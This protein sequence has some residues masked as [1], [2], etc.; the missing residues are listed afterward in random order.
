MSRERLRLELDRLRADG[1]LDEEQ[2]RRVNERLAGALFP[3]ADRVGTLTAI[4]ATFGA[5]LVGTGILFIVAGNW[6]DIPKWW[7]LGLIVGTFMTM[8]HFGF[9]LA[10]R[11]GN[12]PRVGRALTAAGVL[13]YGAVIALVA[14][15]YGLESRYPWALLAW[16]ALNVPIALL[17]RNGWIATIVLSLLGIWANVH[18]IVWIG[19]LPGERWGLEWLVVPSVWLVIGVVFKLVHVLVLR[20]RFHELEQ[21]SRLLATPLVILWIYALS[22]RHVAES[23]PRL[24]SHGWTPYVP[25]AIGAALALVLCAVAW[26][27]GV[28]RHECVDAVLLLLGGAAF[29]VAARMLPGAFFPLSNVALLIVLVVLIARGVQHGVAS[30]VNW[31]VLGFALALFS[32][33]FEFFHEKLPGGAFFG[34]G[35]VLIA[36]ALALE[37]ARK[38][39]LARARETG[40]TS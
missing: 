6:D 34:P 40:A 11:P 3:V 16:G 31:G 18:T 1:V 8:H 7:K 2:C 19:D 26:I 4:I 27:R 5:L 25:F 28:A 36:G 9:T 32:K 15:I 20:T 12:F 24:D 10:E 38:K 23:L 14:Q 37:K 17:T 30:Y 35:I 13:S 33:Y 39:L 22:F 21:P 29:V